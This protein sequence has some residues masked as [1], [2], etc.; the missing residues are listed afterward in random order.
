MNIKDATNGKEMINSKNV[1]S[2]GPQ[3]KKPKKN[4]CLLAAIILFF[5][6]V[7]IVFFVIL[8]Y[9]FSRLNAYMSSALLLSKTPIATVSTTKTRIA[10][11]KTPPPQPVAD[12]PSCIQVEVLNPQPLSISTDDPV[13][14]Q[15]T[16]EEYY[17]IYGTTIN[18]LN[19]Q[20]YDCGPKYDGNSY[21]GI[22]TDNINWSYLMRFNQDGSCR[23]DNLAV[24]VN[25]KIVYPNWDSQDN[26][27][28][29]TKERWNNM[30]ANLKIHEEGHRQIDYDSA[31]E[32][33]NTISTVTGNSCEEVERTVKTEASRI[34][35]Q[36][37][38]KN[39]TY[40]EETNH[41]ETQG[42]NL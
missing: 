8:P 10:A 20:L 34:M 26:A 6:F 40:D 7:M 12:I 5:V 31:A 22:T 35:D 16:I 39:N 32:I 41:G 33:F 4:H 19:S 9:S 24:G 38:Q 23:V 13:L 30:I 37:T 21:A 29:S 15:N 25:V 11:K 3:Q 14:K 18:D 17:K 28:E 36:S 2:S 1:V 42:A 27:T